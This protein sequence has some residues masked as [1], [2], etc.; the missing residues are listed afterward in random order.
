M[1]LENAPHTKVIW[2]FSSQVLDADLA[3]RIAD[4]KVTSLRLV[5]H[6]DAEERI[7]KFIEDFCKAHD[8]TK[9]ESAAIM[10][11][12]SEGARAHIVA[13][14]EP[15]EVQFGEKITFAPKS[16]ADSKA[17]FAVQ[18]RYWE[19]L[20]RPGAM[21]YMGYGLVV[22]KTIEVSDRLVTLEVVMGGQIFPDM[23]IHIP[24]TRA[25]RSLE[26]FDEG[27]LKKLVERHVE[28]IVV[29]G[30]KDVN[31]IHAF[32]AKMEKVSATPPW[33]LLRVDSVKIYEKLD[34]LLPHV[35]GVLISRRELALTTNPATIP[36]MTKEIIQKANDFAKIVV[37]ASEMLGSMRHGPTPTRAEVS[38][39]ANAIHDGSDALVLSEEVTHGRF[40]VRALGVIHR[41]IEDTEKIRGADLNWV[42][43]SPSIE[44]EMDAIAYGAY[45]TAERVGAKAIVCLTK[46]GNTALRLASFRAPVPIVAVTFDP[47]V[48]RRLR[49]VRGVQA[50]VLDGNPAIGEVLPL[51]ND[52]LIRDSWLTA[53]DKIVFV[54]ITLSSVGTKGSNLFTVQQLI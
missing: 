28:Y 1:I 23:E 49:L 11:D 16:A 5:Y 7:P 38:D 9:G 4:E 15:V 44:S 6:G 52:K 12:L 30:V 45:T 8:A 46:A 29:P 37:T 31:E 47:D 21:V 3:R 53:G 51:V 32:K 22:L 20:F 50:L 14:S 27:L 39:I 34:Q 24:E 33:I 41:I 25:K 54:S 35:D 36:M 18:V 19:G 10:V 26:S 42:K 48:A 13:L 40:G 43:V 2:S 17:R